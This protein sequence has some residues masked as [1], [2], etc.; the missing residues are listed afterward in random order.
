MTSYHKWRGSHI[1]TKSVWLLLLSCC[2]L[3]QIGY[4]NERPKVCLALSGGG[5]RGAAHIGILKRLEELKIPVDCIAGTSMGSIVGGLYASI[6]PILVPAV[7]GL[8]LAAFMHLVKQPMRLKK[9]SVP[10]TGNI[11]SMMTQHDKI[12]HFV[13]S[14]KSG[15]I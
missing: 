14:R 1:F 11:F 8:L 5:A 6:D 12:C 10:W 3:P 2:A 7:W 4:A 9:H 15:F 13:V